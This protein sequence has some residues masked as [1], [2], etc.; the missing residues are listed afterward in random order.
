M[1]ELMSELMTDLQQSIFDRVQRMK[2]SP[3]ERRE[4]ARL[5]RT[6][7]VDRFWEAMTEWS[8]RNIGGQRYC[9]RVE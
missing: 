5:E 4:R 3:E 1:E 7:K 6:L 8:L 9:E 2:P